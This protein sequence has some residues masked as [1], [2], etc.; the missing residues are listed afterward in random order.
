MLD[1]FTFVLA[2]NDPLK[3]PLFIAA[4]IIGI[5]LI[6]VS[7]VVGT[8]WGR[9][10]RA[11]AEA[12][13]AERRKARR[14]VQDEAAQRERDLLKRYEDAKRKA[15]D[16]MKTNPRPIVPMEEVRDEEFRPVPRGGGKVEMVSTTGPRY[17][18]IQGELGV[19]GSAPVR[20]STKDTVGVQGTK[21]TETGEAQV[22]Q[23]ARVAKAK[24]IKPGAP[25]PAAVA[26]PVAVRPGPVAPKL[27]VA[28]A[29]PKPVVATPVAPAPEVKTPEPAPEAP[30]PAEKPK[31]AKPAQ[32]EDGID[33]LSEMMTNLDKLKK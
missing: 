20:L 31:D 13:I 28:E 27:P 26:K 11:E 33:K 4:V 7:A 15:E 23:A 21:T 6:I 17:M 2:N 22:A 1:P 25:K 3:D 9:R 12:R 19:S 32:E 10:K 24:P 16:E 29:A 30:K 14:A 18:K 5:I 8:L